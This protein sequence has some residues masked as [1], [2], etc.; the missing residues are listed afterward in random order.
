[1]S[2]PA[3][4][5]AD[6]DLLVLEPAVAPGLDTARIASL[7]PGNRI[8]YYAGARWSGPLGSMVQGS[9]VQAI[10]GSGRLRTVEG[11][12]GR[13]RTSH[14]LGVEIE[15]FEADYGSGEP[16]VARVS[17]TATLARSGDRR[18]LGTWSASADATASANTLS[19]VTAALGQAYGEAGAELL[20]RAL[21]ALAADSEST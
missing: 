4:R 10:R 15:R 2:A 6:A 17:M 8:D 1:V 14:V 7:W 16:P 11:D 3:G 5:P 9:L 13:F 18:A 19:A 21:D 12:P 20:A